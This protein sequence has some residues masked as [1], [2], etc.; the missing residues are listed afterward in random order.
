MNILILGAGAIG[1]YLGG[2]LAAHH[3]VTIYDRARLV[4]AVTTRRQ[5][6]NEHEGAYPVTNLNA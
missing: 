1:G 3:T 6:N 2:K 5:H 4:E